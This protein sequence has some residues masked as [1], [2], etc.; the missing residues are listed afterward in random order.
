MPKLRPK[1][2][3]H[4]STGDMLMR[5]WLVFGVG[6]GLAIALFF[7]GFVCDLIFAILLAASYV[8]EWTKGD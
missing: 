1:I 6:I 3:V 8:R 5:G 2:D 7:G 4:G